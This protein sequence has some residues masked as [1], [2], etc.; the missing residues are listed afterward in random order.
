M[1]VAAERR[2]FHWELELPEVFE[3]GR[4]GFDA[5]VAN[6]PWETVK[7][8][9]QE[10]WSNHN[11]LFRELGKQ[12]A[13]R[14]AED[15]RADAT[16]DADWRAYERG[17]QQQGAFF[18]EGPL[19][20]S[21]GK[22]D[23]NTYK[24]FLERTLGLLREGGGLGIVMPS[25]LYTDLGAKE[26]RE[27]LFATSR[28]RYLLALTNEKYIFPAV[29]HSFRFVLLSLCAGGKTEALRVLY[30]LNIQNA[31]ASHELA[32]LLANL[33]PAT[34][35]LRVADI[36]R[37]S[38]D[39]LSLMEFKSQREVDVAAQIY[40][41][42][43]LLGEEVPE[44]WNIRFAS[45]LHMTGDSELF[46]NRHQ[47]DRL[48][49]SSNGNVFLPLFE[50]KILHQFSASF[51][52]PRY[53]VREDDAS[54]KLDRGVSFGRYRAAYR[55]I[56]NSQNERT[57]IVSPLPKNVVLGHSLAAIVLK[58]NK[59]HCELLLVTSLMNS[60][61]L[62]LVQRMK[63]NANLTMFYVYQL[64]LPRLT[65]GSPHFD[66]L[67]PRAARLTC[68]SPEFAGLWNEIAQHYPELAGEDPLRFTNHVLRAQLR[69]E[70]DALVADLYG[71]SE[72]DFA[73][74]LS[75][76][77]LLDRGQP[78]LAGDVDEKGA[79][80]S[81]ITR[82]TALLELFKLRGKTPPADIVAFFATAGADI[83]RLTGPL[84]GL[85]ERVAAALALGAVGYVPGG[86]GRDVGEGEEGEA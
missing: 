26:L 20:R 14:F 84:R 77:P 39:S 29:H 68:T 11:P 40:D 75:T 50:G 78:A 22:G 66:A 27:R 60:F 38:P 36:R 82:D 41:G 86:R 44:A 81:Y 33:E 58:S 5:L 7:P 53:W 25:G 83:A 57:L 2:F 72:E 24:L 1:R 55:L 35:D 9:S 37:F 74:I 4:D 62:D 49:K 12:A 64:P 63:T 70:I 3:G 61:I 56:Q 17:E 13:L 34:L 15:L 18:K 54:Q 85:G 8:N 48:L 6:P 65:H 79:S 28:V 71:L 23:T 67:V 16:I 47:L 69:A 30:R 46:Y 10:F 76:F 42:H 80:R 73:Y 31:V 52:E 43:P 51:A 45:E 21:Q 32:G 59:Y 19:Y